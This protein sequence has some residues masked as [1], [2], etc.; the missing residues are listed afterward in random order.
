MPEIIPS[1]T[2]TTVIHRL[3]PEQKPTIRGITRGGFSVGFAISRDHIPPLSGLVRYRS[4]LANVAEAHTG[5]GVGLVTQT[6]A[7][8]RTCDHIADYVSLAPQHGSGPG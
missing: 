8:C 1:T 6:P 5:G 2:T 7:I 4:W 3:W